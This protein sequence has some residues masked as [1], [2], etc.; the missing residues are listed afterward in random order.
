M[1]GT[2]NPDLKLSLTSIRSTLDLL[3]TG[4]LSKESL[5][6][7]LNFSDHTRTPVN[8]RIKQHS[9]M[10]PNIEPFEIGSLKVSDLHTL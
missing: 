10:Y 2:E 5:N 3:D 9:D 7:C 8:G 6:N 1:T 4:D